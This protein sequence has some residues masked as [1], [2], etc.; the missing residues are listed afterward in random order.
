LLIVQRL[1]PI[2]TAKFDATPR[3]DFSVPEHF[4]RA[5][6][7]SH[8]LLAVL[9]DL[10]QTTDGKWMTRGSGALPEVDSLIKSFTQQV[11]IRRGTLN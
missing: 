11:L 9:G 5:S 2:M 8:R 10:V 3:T 1:H 4:G 7:R 6:H